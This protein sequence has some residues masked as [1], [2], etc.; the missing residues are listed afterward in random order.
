MDVSNACCQHVYTQVSN[1]LTFFRIC[2]LALTNNTIFFAADCSDLCFQGHS[3]LT[4]DCDQLFCLCHILLDRIV[5]TVEHN[6]RKSCL[7][8]F[9][10]SIIGTVIQMKSYRNGNSHLF[11]HSGHH[12]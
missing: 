2:A 9:H 12:S 10:A 6:G 4:A 7:D 8:T 5:G 11:D 3:L 1:H